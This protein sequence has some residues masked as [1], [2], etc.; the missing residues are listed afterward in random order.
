MFSFLFLFCVLLTTI[1]MT[2]IRRMA[3]NKKVAVTQQEESTLS[4]DPSATGV[5]Q[6]Q[7]S[8]RTGG[9]VAN[10]D[11]SNSPEVDFDE[12]E[13]GE[14]GG[15]EDEAPIGEIPRSPTPT[16]AGIAKKTFESRLRAA[17][18]GKTTLMHTIQKVLQLTYARELKTADIEL[19]FAD[20]HRL[21]YDFDP[22][23]VRYSRNCGIYYAPS[24]IKFLNVTYPEWRTLDDDSLKSKLLAHFRRATGNGDSS[25]DGAN[26]ITVI[27]S[28]WRPVSDRYQVY[29]KDVKRDGE[30]TLI[31]WTQVE[32]ALKP[33]ESTWEQPDQEKQREWLLRLVQVLFDPRIKDNLRGNKPIALD[34]GGHQ[35]SAQEAALTTFCIILGSTV[36]PG[37]SSQKDLFWTHMLMEEPK[38]VTTVEELFA[39]IFAIA[40]SREALINREQI[41]GFKDLPVS[42]EPSSN[43]VAVADPPSG[44]GPR[45]QGV[46]NGVTRTHVTTG[47][48]SAST[49][50]K[51]TWVTPKPT[52][53][54]GC[55][56]KNHKPDTCYYRGHPYYNTSH[57]PWYLSDIGKKWHKD[58][59]GRDPVKSIRDSTWYETHKESQPNKKQRGMLSIIHVLCHTHVYVNVENHSRLKL[60]ALL[61]TGAD[62]EGFVS[63]KVAK[64][65]ARHGI[66][67]YMTRENED[68][69]GAG[70]EVTYKI[71]G[72]VETFYIILINDLLQPINILL[73]NIRILNI[74]L[75]MILGLPLIKTYDLTKEMRSLFI[76]TEEPVTEK[77]RVM[78]RI[79]H[80]HHPIIYAKEE[81]ID[82]LEGDSEEPF[83]KE[84]IDTL[85]PRAD[86]V[87]DV[88]ATLPQLSEGSDPEGILQR[89]LNEFHDV[90]AR[91]ISAQP[92][93]VEPM[94][95]IMK[96]GMEWK[97][98]GPPRLQSL[99]KQQALLK[100][101]DESLMSGLIARSQASSYSQI[102]M[103][104]KTNGKWR[105]CV[106]Y[107][108]LNERLESMSWPLPNINS[109]LRRIGSKK[110]QYFAVLDLTSGYHQVSLEIGRASCRER[111]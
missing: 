107:R 80:N 72:R 62:A 28:F 96:Q 14:Y 87:L 15:D 63:V 27:D 12:L 18:Q 47:V 69:Q 90:F 49:T 54:T 61:D 85:L 110:P 34:A 4:V 101:I 95:L 7:V 66:K 38:P 86:D 84:G 51:G 37:I 76:S 40:K 19:H 8:T 33:Y 57:A 29:T 50:A 93:A 3:R 31:L 25:T 43:A 10:R 103:V 36:N 60:R 105:F 52:F 20:L 44:E 65:L 67:S 92:A 5:R 55:G 108:A 24:F 32:E 41:L 16:L 39:L 23:M 73:N 109:M 71:M 100:F 102:V 97:S 48:S 11:P 56:N 2:S 13:E 81:L 83:W 53:C 88:Q 45:H 104:A 46:M 74:N 94:K 91:T 9:G 106:D 78:Q 82:V 26:I 21:S 75:D 58:H 64:L 6:Q 30:A 22:G 111:V 35:Q 42:R 70:D 59:P 99:T 68:I 1:S 77:L 98:A 79:P 89:M 17:E